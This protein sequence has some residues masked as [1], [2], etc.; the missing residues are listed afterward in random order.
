MLRAQQRG[1]A[2]DGEA[3]RKLLKDEVANV[4]KQQHDN[5]IDIVSDG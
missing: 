3:Y 5:G 1:E 4:V 2:V